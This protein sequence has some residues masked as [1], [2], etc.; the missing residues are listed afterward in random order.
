MAGSVLLYHK[1]KA[2][3]SFSS[4]LK[5]DIHCIERRKLNVRVS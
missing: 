3:Y 1:V 4:R 5:I 2:V